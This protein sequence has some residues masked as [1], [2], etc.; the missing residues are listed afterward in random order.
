[1]RDRFLGIIAVLC[2]IGLILSIGYMEKLEDDLAGTI[3]LETKDGTEVV[4]PVESHAYRK[5]IMYA[6][7]GIILY[8]TAALI[9]LAPKVYWYISIF[10]YW[11]FHHEPE[12][13]END[14]RGMK[15]VK[16]GL[17]ILGCIAFAAVIFYMR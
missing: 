6:F 7:F 3:T 14:E 8:A 16:Y 5:P 10:G 12:M 15:I 11:R 13:T 2:V 1:M 9:F 17:F 4:F